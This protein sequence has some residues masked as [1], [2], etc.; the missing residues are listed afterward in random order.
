MLNTDSGPAL[1]SIEAFDPQGGLLGRSFQ[2]L[3]AE[4]KR[5]FLLRE[6]MPELGEQSGGY[7]R[8][9]STRKVLGFELFGNQD[10]VFL[11]AVSQQ[12]VVE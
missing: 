5:A 8:I 11:S 2:I 1:I 10:L 3:L 12:K 6:L 7:L 9:R 4:E